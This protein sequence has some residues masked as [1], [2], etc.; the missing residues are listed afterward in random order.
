MTAH[1]PLSHS[2]EIVLALS[3]AANLNI[4]SCFTAVPLH[5]EVQI[6]Q[7]SHLNVCY[8]PASLL[9]SQLLHEHKVA[10]GIDDLRVQ[11]LRLC[12]NPQQKSLNLVTNLGE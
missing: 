6:S 3:Y 8:T 2:A 4:S 5:T 1:L 11:D 12:D 7:E 9:C 10:A